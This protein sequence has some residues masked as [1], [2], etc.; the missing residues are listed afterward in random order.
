MKEIE[1]KILNIDRKKTEKQLNSL[2]AKKIFDDEITTT[3]FDF[4]DS[5]IKKAKN[6]IRL[7]KSGNKSYVTF[8]KYIE[9]AQMKVRQEFEVEVSD[10]TTM[11][12]ILT[13][14]GL[15]PE[16]HIKKHRVSYIL[17]DVHFEFDT[18]IEEYGFIPEFLEI[19]AKD[20]DTL[21]SYI[22]KLGF[23]K[24]QCKSWSFFEVADY[25]KTK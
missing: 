15:L 24:D 4:S 22:Q 16:L 21:S 19:E 18:H 13:S 10:F 9:H 8:K 23:S 14:L 3:L 5:S 25:Y 2:G 17:D 1:V 11:S 12:N 20:E 6:L 7:R